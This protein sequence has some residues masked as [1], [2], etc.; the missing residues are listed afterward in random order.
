MSSDNVVGDGTLM[1]GTTPV[2]DGATVPKTFVTDKIEWAVVL[3]TASDA[4]GT[5]VSLLEDD[6]STL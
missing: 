3:F 1:L 5:E 6:K 2:G 4:C